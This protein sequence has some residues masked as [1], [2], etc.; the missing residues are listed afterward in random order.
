AAYAAA[1]AFVLLPLGDLLVQALPLAP[2]RLEWR[3]G[4]IG[5]SATILVF[6]TVA[7]VFATLLGSGMDHP[8]ALVVFSVL[9]LV[10]ALVA[11]SMLGLVVLDARQALASVVQENRAT[12]LRQMGKSA[13]NLAVYAGLNTWVFVAALA[14][15]RRARANKKSTAREAGIVAVA[16]P[17]RAG[18]AS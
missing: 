5:A 14:A 1:I 18:A 7:I 11:L 17:G 2:N 3:I 15:A 13:L 8:M 6:P 16:A 9:A 10:V 12:F 4:V